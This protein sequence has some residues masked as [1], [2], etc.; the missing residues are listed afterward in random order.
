LAAE[1]RLER[2]REL[3]GS[4][5][6]VV[7]QYPGRGVSGGLFD[8]EVDPALPVDSLVRVRLAS[9]RDDATLVGEAR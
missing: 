6:L 1:M 3:V 8:V 5:D 4:E 7:V 2:A 9:V